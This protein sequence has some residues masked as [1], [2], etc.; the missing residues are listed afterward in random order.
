MIE[1]QNF[2]KAS[3]AELKQVVWPNKKQVLRLTII[4]IAVSVAT[5]AFIG[6]LDYVFTNFVGLLVK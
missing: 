5:G 3:I 2:I 1:S 6:G 4:V